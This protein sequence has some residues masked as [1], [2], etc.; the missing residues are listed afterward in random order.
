M[1]QGYQ[2]HEANYLVLQA[3]PLPRQAPQEVGKKA[4][5]VTNIL[6]EVRIHDPYSPPDYT[7]FALLLYV[8]C[9]SGLS[10]SAL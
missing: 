7:C 5:L 4:H 3:V 8:Q 1:R 6:I 2:R 10:T 9:H